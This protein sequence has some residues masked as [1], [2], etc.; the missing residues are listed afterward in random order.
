MKVT[1]EGNK[2]K[3]NGA[4]GWRERFS[5][6]TGQAL[7]QYDCEG[8]CE[9]F[10]Y[11]SALNLCSL[12]C[13]EFHNPAIWQARLYGREMQQY[14]AR[15]GRNNVSCHHISPRPSAKVGGEAGLQRGA[16]DYEQA[17]R[18]WCRKISPT[19][20]IEYALV[21]RDRWFRS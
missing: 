9:I 4:E 15:F 17:R 2:V 19:R 1:N 5:W 12:C 21:T 6:R 13:T 14:T 7:K 16:L 3:G 10:I 20:P 8:C 18:H 11:F